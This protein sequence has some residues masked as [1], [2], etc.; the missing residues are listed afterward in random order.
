LLPAFV[1]LLGFT[2]VTPLYFLFFIQQIQAVC[3]YF[4][5]ILCKSLRLFGKSSGYRNKSLQY[6]NRLLQ[7]YNGLLQYRNGLLQYCG[8]SPHICN[9]RIIYIQLFKAIYLRILDYFL[10]CS[11]LNRK[12]KGVTQV[13]PNS[14][15]KA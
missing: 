1:L 7:Y 6:Y 13:K 5:H 12:Y 11:I 14:S 8:K 15:T 4:N 2:C 9:G 3:L 10:P